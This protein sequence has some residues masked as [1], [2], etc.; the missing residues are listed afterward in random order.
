MPV[1][2]GS[3]WPNWTSSPAKAG[4]KVVREGELDRPG[5]RLLRGLRLAHVREPRP[6]G[7]RVDQAR[8]ERHDQLVLCEVVVAA[9]AGERPDGRD[10]GDLRRDVQP[11]AEALG[12]GAA[13]VDGGAPARDER[14]D[15]VEARRR[16]RRRSGRRPRRRA[17][18]ASRA[19]WPR[20]SAGHRAAAAART[21]AASASWPGCW[22]RRRRRPGRPGRRPGVMRA[23]A[24]EK[25]MSTSPSSAASAV[26]AARV[27]DVEHAALD[28]ASRPARRGRRGATRSGP[29]PVS[30]TRSRRHAGGEPVDER[31]A[32]ALVGARDEGDAGSGHA[33]KLA[34]LRDMRERELSTATMRF[35][36]A[37]LLAD[38]AARAARGR[39]VRARSRPRPATLGYTQSA[40]SRQVAALE[41][42]AGRRLFERGRDGVT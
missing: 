31:A 36:H 4:S 24:L 2:H 21:R 6:R 22:S 27:A 26:I 37:G 32:E 11:R 17:C 12:L 39:A 28:A 7:V 9:L 35:T 1:S 29:R 41:A 33:S 20:R 16:P 23:V 34:P 10:L 18:R 3:T 40:V 15:G 25:T 8:A 30:R 42:V 14:V 5:G 38:R 13:G 19:R